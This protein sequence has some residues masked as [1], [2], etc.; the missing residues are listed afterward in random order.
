MFLVSAVKTPFLNF[1]FHG[2]WMAVHLLLLK[3]NWS[4]ST[5]FLAGQKQLGKY[6]FLMI[7]ETFLANDGGKM[8]RINFLLMIDRWKIGANFTIKG[9]DPLKR[10]ISLSKHVK[11]KDSGCALVGRVVTSNPNGPQFKSSHWQI[12]IEHLFTF[13]FSTVSK[14]Q[15]TKKKMPGMAN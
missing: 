4:K 6:L 7:P 5:V 12:L 3:L 13:L 14:R 2:A 8:S 11:D 10:K 15:N 9:N 1:I